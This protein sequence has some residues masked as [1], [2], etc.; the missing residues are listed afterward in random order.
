MF[1]KCFRR[2]VIVLGLVCLAAH[3]VSAAGRRLTSQDILI[4]IPGFQVGTFIPVSPNF[5]YATC[6]AFPRPMDLRCDLFAQG[7]FDAEGRQYAMRYTN[8]SVSP[9]LPRTEI[10]RTTL[11][12]GSELL[13]YL[14]PR[15]NELGAYDDG[16]IEKIAVDSVQ[17]HLYLVLAT[18]C[19]PPDQDSCSYGSRAVEIVRITGLRSLADVLNVSSSSPDDPPPGGSGRHAGSTT[20]DH[21]PGGGDEDR[22]PAGGSR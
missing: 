20:I 9:V 16:R 5:D 1:M 19:Y 14:D 13:A 2:A 11:N 18:T 7:G 12:G 21:R 15:A 3:G 10:W 4:V 22:I 17:G 8:S 6:S